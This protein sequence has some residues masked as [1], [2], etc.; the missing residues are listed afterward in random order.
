MALELE[1]I[2]P[3]TKFVMIGT[4]IVFFLIGSVL[5]KPT[6]PLWIFKHILAGM[7]YLMGLMTIHSGALTM[8][9]FMLIFGALIMLGV[10]KMLNYLFPE[11]D[12]I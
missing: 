4:V 6:Q 8:N 7:G 12:L 3:N 11:G 2:T 5:L 9:P 10:H 1:L